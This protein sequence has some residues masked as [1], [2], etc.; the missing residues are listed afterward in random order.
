[1]RSTKFYRLLVVLISILLLSAVSFTCVYA[2]GETEPTPDYTLNAS[3]LF[4]G[5]EATL[6]SEALTGLS[7]NMEGSATAKYANKVSLDNLSLT[8]GFTEENTVDAKTLI[9]TISFGTNNTVYVNKDESGKFYVKLND[10]EE[11]EVVFEGENT[12]YV[13]DG[14]MN[15]S[16]GANEY[17]L[18]SISSNDVDAVN[19]SITS[20]KSVNVKIQEF[21]GVNFKVNK[22]TSDMTTPVIITNGKFFN[23]DKAVSG[24]TYDV[25]YA[26]YDMLSSVTTKIEYIKKSVYDAD[27]TAEWTVTN[28]ND[29]IWFNAYDCEFMVRITATNKGDKVATYDKV[30]SVVKNSAENSIKYQLNKEQYDKYQ[31]E[32]IDVLKV[33][34]DD[35]LRINSSY[36]APSLEDIISSDYFDYSAL[37]FKTHYAYNGASSYQSTTSLTFTLNAT[38]SYEFYVTA[39]DKCKTEFTIETDALNK[40]TVDGI[41]G[42]YNDTDELVCPIFKFNVNSLVAPEI[43]V[44]TG[45]AADGYVGTSYSVSDKFTVKGGNVSKTYKLYYISNANYESYKSANGKEL[46]KGS[47]NTDAEYMDAIETLI[48]ENKVVEIKTVDGEDDPV[49]LFDSA[50]TSFTPAKFGRYYVRL[51]VYDEGGNDSAMSYAINVQRTKTSAVYEKTPFFEANWVSFIF[52]GLAV[53]SFIGILLILFIKPKDGTTEVKVA[54]D[55]E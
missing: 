8:F 32:V 55:A 5:V 30:V 18:D 34:T 1:M 2:E 39:Y 9:Y 38:G 42:W 52:L 29:E 27:N 36:K 26:A 6:D 37:T 46:N 33:G 35:E 7:F 47:F 23:R 48:S 16:C 12:L 19:F 4:T 45:N 21:N 20:S 44:N 54:D 49:D 3:S 14:V 13:V 25:D 28:D 15:L 53:L 24:Y 41:Y 22:L 11:T 31:Q 10:N 43:T 40:K 17:A 50:R 51:D